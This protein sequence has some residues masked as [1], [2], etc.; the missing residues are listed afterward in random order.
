MPPR[1]SAV[2]A[3]FVGRLCG[4]DRARGGYLCLVVDLADAGGDVLG[5]GGDI[6]DAAAHFGGGGRLFLDGGGDG[7]LMV[8]DSIDDGGD[9]V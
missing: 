8:A 3:S 2:R 6:V 1:R 9:A 7:G 4:G 5:A